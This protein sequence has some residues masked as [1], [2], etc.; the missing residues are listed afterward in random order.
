L[1][2]VLD[3]ARASGDHGAEQRWRLAAETTLHALNDF[4][5]GYWSAYDSRMREP[6]SLHY[7]KNIHIPQLRILASLTGEPGFSTV[8]ER[9]E[10]YLNSAFARARL[11]VSYRL[12]R[13]SK[14]R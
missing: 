11:A 1:F 10:R 5:L 9:W 13:F 14:N 4:D 2:G 6:A 7:H 3:Y 12:H 8:A